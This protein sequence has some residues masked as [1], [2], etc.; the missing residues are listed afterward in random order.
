V[1]WLIDKTLEGTGVTF[2]VVAAPA[3]GYTVDEWWKHEEGLV[4]FQNEV[5]KYGFYRLHY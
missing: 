5:V 3:W 1:R 4:D 2:V